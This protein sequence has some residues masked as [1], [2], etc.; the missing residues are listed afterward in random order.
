M[1]SVDVVCVGVTGHYISF[2]KSHEHWLLL[3]D[4]TVEPIDEQVVQTAFGSTNEYHHATNQ[5]PMEH[6][7][8]LLYERQLSDA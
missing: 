6:G 7:Y 1:R 5:Q 4:E 3:D 8:I 2:V